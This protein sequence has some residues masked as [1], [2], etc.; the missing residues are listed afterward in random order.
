MPPL[1][2]QRAAILAL[3]CGPLYVAADSITL[4]ALEVPDGQLD[5]YIAT[6]AYPMELRNSIEALAPTATPRQVIRRYCGDVRPTY[7]KRFLAANALKET[8]LDQPAP[9]DRELIW[10]ACIFARDYRNGPQEVIT[11][12]PKDSLWS[13]HLR[14]TG[15]KKFADSGFFY[16]NPDQA[17]RKLSD[18]ESLRISYFTQPTTIRLKVEQQEFLA[19]LTG[20]AGKGWQERLAVLPPFYG[21]ILTAFGA[22]ANDASTRRCTPST[23]PPF[24]GEAVLKTYLFALLI[25]P[26]KD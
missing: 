14:F 15:R 13:L 7:L 11:A 4:R 5:D 12:G 19:G 6:Q 17:T 2:V 23:I 21:R 3:L 20:V 22:A 18:G 10:P 25:R 24:A 9:D 26:H 16:L 8:A 1:V